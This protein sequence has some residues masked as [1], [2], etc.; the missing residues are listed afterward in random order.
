[1]QELHNTTEYATK[2]KLALSEVQPNYVLCSNN[3]YSVGCTSES[4]NNDRRYIELAKTLKSIH[5]RMS[6][7]GFDFNKKNY[8]K[9]TT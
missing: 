6:A 3:A 4:V 1:M 7:M 2:Q 8:E 5:I 9:Q